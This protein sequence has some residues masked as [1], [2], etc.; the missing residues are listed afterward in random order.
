MCQ[1]LLCRNDF[2]CNAASGTMLLPQSNCL[3]MCKQA[4]VI[5]DSRWCVMSGWF[6]QAAFPKVP[7]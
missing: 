5:L 6:R 4:G 1:S 7:L 3:E 2:A